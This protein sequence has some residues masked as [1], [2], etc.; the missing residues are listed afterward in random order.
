MHPGLIDFRGDGLKIELI[1][2]NTFPDITYNDP[3][4]KSFVIPGGRFEVQVKN[5]CTLEFGLRLN[6]YLRTPQ[7]Q[8]AENIQDPG[9]DYIFAML[10]ETF[11]DSSVT[12]KK[13]LDLGSG[14]GLTSSI[15]GLLYQDAKISAMDI[16]DGYLSESINN[17]S[18]LS[19]V[20]GNQLNERINMM[21][22]N[23][24]GDESIQLLGEEATYDVI[25]ISPSIPSDIWQDRYLP[26]LRGSGVMI[27]TD[28]ASHSL[29]VY[30]GWQ[31][32]L[33]DTGLKIPTRSAYEVSTG[34]RRMND[35]MMKKVLSSLLSFSDEE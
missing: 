9:R 25:F 23:I 8:T 5:D 3:L 16:N 18:K 19:G 10:A 11:R 17:I 4:G 30:S 32:E 12:V 22:G 26:M 28:E 24:I 27:F 34:K 35:D 7:W 13:V 2:G 15:F 31:K 14:T 21:A 33:Y 1:P 20:L 29:K 6:P